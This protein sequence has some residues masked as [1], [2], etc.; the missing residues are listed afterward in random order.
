MDKQ[1]ALKQYFGHEGFRPGQEELVEGILQGRDVLGV[2]PTG[3]GKSVCYQ[4]PALLLPGITLVVSPLISLMKDQVMALTEAGV[5][6]AFVNSSLTGE[7]MRA[8]YRRAWAGE[9][10][11]IY[12]APERLAAEGFLNMARSLDISLVA[13]DEAHCVSQWGQDFRPSYL[14]IPEFLEQL[15]RRPRLAAFTAT[16]TGQVREDIVRLLGLQDP[17]T[18]V[19]GY[20]RPNLYFEVYRP[21]SKSAALR[22]L[23]SQR[24]GKSGIVYCATRSAVEKVCEELRDQGIPATRYHA[25]LEEDERRRNQDDFRF[26]RCPIM[27]ATNA[28]GMGIDKSNVSFVIHYN[29][30]KSLEAYYQEAGRAGR[31]GERAECILLYSAKDIETAKFLIEN[32]HTNEELSEAEQEEALRRD[33]RRLDAMIGYCKTTGCLRGCILD[34][35]GQEHAERC[36]DCGNCRADYVV[37]DITRQAQMVLSCVVRVNDR[38]GYSVGAGLITQVLKGGRAKRVL[39]L[40]LDGLSTYGLMKELSTA[41]IGGYIDFLKDKGYLEKDPDHGALRLTQ[42]SGDILFRGKSLEM[43]AR[44][45]P[46]EEA[47]Q[48]ESGLL[49]SLKDLRYRLAQKEGV[50]PFMIFSNATL[51]DMAL[52]RPRSLADFLRVSGVGEVKARKYGTAF[53]LAIEDAAESGSEE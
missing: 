10:K 39:E 19:T 29:M 51:T 20:D 17:L 27:V 21:R 43:P 47:R 40:G 35:F 7:Q 53:L 8:V 3:G 30:P 13:V 1:G 41:Q 4:L 38:L 16:A 23:L 26:D 18:L 22:D 37:T 2:M 14:K 46:A 42:A 6:A 9:F 28:F 32:G 31:D 36:G 48:A 50:P 11:L 5:K 15:P 44:S 25:G 24:V 52:K 49:Q 33:Y 34:Y 45:A 12:V